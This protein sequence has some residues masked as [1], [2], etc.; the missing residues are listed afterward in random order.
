MFK[1]KG[2]IILLMTLF[3]TVSFVYGNTSDG[4]EVVYRESG[5]QSATGSHKGDVLNL[6]VKAKAAV[7]LDGGSGTFLYTQNAHE[8]L[9]PA[10][11]T[12]IMTMLLTMEAVERGQI[13]LSDKVT[14]S[15]RAASMG[16]SQMYMEAGEQ[17]S[18]ENLLIG[19]AVCS[20]NDACV[21]CGEYVG[22]TEE[23]FV[24]MMNKRAKELGMK[25]T[26]FINTNG[27]PV[28]DHY[29]SAYDIGLMSKELLSFEE[30]KKW[31][32][33]WQTTITVG[34]PGKKQTELGLTNTNR[35][36]KLYPG[37]NGIKTGFTQEAGY[38]LA[39]SATKGDLTLIAV[40]MGCES[41][42]I[43]WSETMRLLDYGFAT[44][45]SVKLA[46]P[47]ENFG[48]VDIDKAKPNRVGAISKDAISILV[49]KGERDKI[50]T[51]TL[52]V[53]GIK[54]PIKMGDRIGELVVYKGGKELERHPLV[55]DA[56][57]EKA[58]LGEIYI[59]MVR[60]LLLL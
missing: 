38:C 13:K 29:T 35:L 20:A 49:K 33:I 23:I 48:T 25:N 55:A 11:V 32:N 5:V 24:E 53:K 52:Y 21:A 17:Q 8:S 31:F 40:V 59:R 7:L 58:G 10:S 18:V 44:Y 46:S 2:S 37:A 1:I 15:P 14:I 51:K 9:P 60:S 12:K 26:N 45:D 4:E 28:P 39:G 30:T 6:D 43:R 54:A 3:M 27:L 57:A 34:L 41:T 36:I 47:G 50:T 19:M 16:G 22:G 56:G 42:G